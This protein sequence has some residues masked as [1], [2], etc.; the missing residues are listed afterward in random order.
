MARAPIH[1]GEH[2]AEQLSKLGISAAEAAQ[3]LDMPVARVTEILNR[4]GRVTSDIAARLAGW[5]GTSPQFWLNL[6]QLY[7]SRV[8][9]RAPSA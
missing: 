5:F 4:E 2:L 8:N 7:D 3:H 9:R 6:Q 1:P